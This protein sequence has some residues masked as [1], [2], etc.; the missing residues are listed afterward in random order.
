MQYHLLAVGLMSSQSRN[1]LETEAE[2]GQAVA[3][4]FLPMRTSDS[5]RELVE[6]L[7]GESPLYHQTGVTLDGPKLIERLG[8]ETV[9]IDLEETINRACDD[10]FDSVNRIR[11]LARLGFQIFLME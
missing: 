3:E 9:L 2:N 11:E 10:E 6:A 5:S 8:L 1:Y 7:T 4:V